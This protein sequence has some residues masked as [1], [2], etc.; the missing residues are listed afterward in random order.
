MKL[1]YLIYAT[2][3][4]GLSAMVGYRI[5]KNKNREGT[6]GKGGPGKGNAGSAV[7]VNGVVVQPQRFANSV[8]ISGTLDANEQVSLRSQVSGVVT[9]LYFKEGSVAKKGQPLIQIDN[10]ELKAQLS[11][12]ETR[13]NLAAENLKRATQLLE[14]GAISKQEFDIVSADL[15]SLQAQTQLIRAQIAKT[16][17][18]AP[19]NGTIGLRAISEG[20]YLSPET[21]VARLVNTHPLKLTFSVPEK[22][23]SQLKVNTN[24]TFTVSGSDQKYKARVYAIEPSIEATTRT[25]QLRAQVPNPDGELRPGAFANVELPLS[26]IED[27]LL[28]PTEAVVPVQNGKKVFVK[29]QGKAKEVMVETST[30]REKDILITSGLQ[31]GDTVLTTGVMSLRSGTPVTVIIQQAGSKTVKR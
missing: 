21:V 25:L 18:R 27:A 19:F 20:E 12:A 13:Q 11:Q 16:T 10:S 3:V 31:V 15:K 30:R 8:F 7:R 28:V 24:L 22:Y 23:A 6:E 1:K 2:L 14:K 29:Q 26:I 4:I 17:I 9:N 5:V